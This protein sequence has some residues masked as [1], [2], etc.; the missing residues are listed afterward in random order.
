MKTVRSMTIALAGAMA[1]SACAFDVNKSSPLIFGQAAT[2]G[3]SVGP[4]TTGNSAE[5][6]VGVKMADIAVVPTV[7]PAD[8]TLPDQD[9][10]TRNIRSFGK[11]ENGKSPSEDALSTFGSFS[12]D[13][14]VNQVKLGIFFATGVAAQN[15]SAAF[16]CSINSAGHQDCPLTKDTKAPQT[17][18][19]ENNNS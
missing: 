2:V 7:V 16:A 13:T 19:T 18:E 9:H 1:L 5:M 15:I 3:I 10:A 4:S 17:E 11:A 14:Q 6:V 12:S 8:V